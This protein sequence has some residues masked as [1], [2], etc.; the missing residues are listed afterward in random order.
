M[1]FQSASLV[2]V[3]S[4]DGAMALTGQYSGAT[5]KK[6]ATNTWHLVGDIG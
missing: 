2:N 5:L 1:L 6:V 4:K 3:Y